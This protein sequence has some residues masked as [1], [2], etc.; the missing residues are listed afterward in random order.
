MRQVTGRFFP[1]AIGRT[2][3]A[4]GVFFRAHGL[5]PAQFAFPE[6]SVAQTRPDRRHELGF[7]PDLL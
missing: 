3:P 1:L 5:V 2:G 7:D 6:Q 4:E